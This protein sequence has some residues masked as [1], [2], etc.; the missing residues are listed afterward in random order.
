MFLNHLLYPDAQIPAGFPSQKQKRSIQILVLMI[1]K[2]LEIWSIIT[3]KIEICH[4]FGK[5]IR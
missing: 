5:E 3:Q 4:C 2:S 1:F